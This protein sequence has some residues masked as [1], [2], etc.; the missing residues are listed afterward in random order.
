M[1]HL[2]PAMA[3]VVALSAGVLSTPAFAA[4]A[5]ESGPGITADV[6]A[7]LAV[8]TDSVLL[9]AGKTGI[10]SRTGT[11]GTAVHRWTRLADGVTTA[12]P[13]GSYWGSAGTDLVVSRQGAVFTLTDMS[14]ATEPVVLDTSAFNTDATPYVVDRVVG[15]S[16]LMT[17]TVNGATEFHLVS[18][19]EDGKAADR[20]VGLP[21][22][23]RPWFSYSS[24]PDSLAVSYGEP[25]QNGYY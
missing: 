8:P 13:A 19:D 18:L 3:L 6:V 15:R 11:G 7:P 16:L 20:K 21:D 5:A 1:K 10:L 23:S 14:G 24:G 17:A 22:G 2:S 25:I 9:S 12:L 4:R